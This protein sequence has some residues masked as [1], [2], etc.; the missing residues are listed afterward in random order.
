MICNEGHTRLCTQAYVS[1]LALCPLVLCA[2][3]IA[4]SGCGQSSLPRKEV[5]Q[6]QPPKGGFSSE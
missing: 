6:K 4:V 1:V 5:I 3:I 2:G